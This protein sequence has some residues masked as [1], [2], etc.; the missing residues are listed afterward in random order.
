MVISMD[1]ER[2]KTT[3]YNIGRVKFYDKKLKKSYHKI[4]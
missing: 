2:G 3:I 1:E 4:H